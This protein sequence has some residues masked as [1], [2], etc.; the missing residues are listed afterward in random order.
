MGKTPDGMNECDLPAELAK[1][2]RKLE[3]KVALLEKENVNLK[4]RIA[5]KSIPFR[6]ASR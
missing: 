4:A 5:L 3:E 2:M 1:R 6:P